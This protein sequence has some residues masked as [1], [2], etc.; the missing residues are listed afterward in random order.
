MQTPFIADIGNEQIKVK[1]AKSEL[2]FP[3]ALI[4][5]SDNEWQQLEHRRATNHPD[6][7]IVNG[8]PYVFGESAFRHS[9]IT[10][11][12]GAERYDR[13]YYGVLAAV[14]MAR[15]YQMSMTHVFWFG[16]HAPQDV[17][18]ADALMESVIG[19]HHVIHNGKDLHFV[20]QDGSTF[21][22]P[23]G[24][25]MNVYLT[26]QGGLR[27]NGLV[28]GMTAV[29]DVGGFT[30]DTLVIDQRGQ[31]DYRLTRSTNVGVLNIIDNFVT[32][33]KTHNA[34]MLKSVRQLDPLRTREAIRTGKYKL[35]G[36]GTIDC[37]YEAEAAITRVVNDVLMIFQE[38]GGAANYDHVV[39]TGGGGELIEPYLSHALHHDSISLADNAGEVHLA[40]VRG[41]MKYYRLLQS[42]GVL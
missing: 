3:H 36:M 14:A 27:R 15:L 34:D 39:L 10:R 6:Y 13:H 5:L 16:S 2:T 20:V 17:D 32:A 31:V 12:K 19:A 33:F 41:G 25:A 1:A 18:Y 35:G 23:L 22:E 9:A 28:G 11:R 4:E 30:T 37:Q 7:A 29:I 24:G 38:I 21:D 42:Q 26:E 40:N 8:T